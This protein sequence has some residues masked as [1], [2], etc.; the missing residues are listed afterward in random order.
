MFVTT[1]LTLPLGAPCVPGNTLNSST[2]TATRGFE[3]T[4]SPVE[5]E[6]ETAT[7]ATAA[8]PSASFR[9]E[10]TPFLLPDVEAAWCI[11]TSAQSGFPRIRPAA[12]CSRVGVP[13]ALPHPS[14]TKARFSFRVDDALLAS[15]YRQSHFES[16]LRARFLVKRSG[17]GG[18]SRKGTVSRRSSSTSTRF[19]TS[20]SYDAY[21]IGTG[22]YL[23]NWQKGPPL[24]RHARPASSPSG[25]RGCLPP[26]R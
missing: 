20:A 7:A 23:G 15:R 16:Y 19:A 25:R 2:W 13:A 17:G 4:P 11:E 9:I 21:V 5:T 8:I 24:H 18:W 3:V 22:I 1:N 14:T 26:A 6:P 10:S 12:M